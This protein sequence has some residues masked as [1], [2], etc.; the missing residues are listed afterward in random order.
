MQSKTGFEQNGFKTIGICVII[1]FQKEGTQPMPLKLRTIHE[2]MRQ[3][4]ETG[5]PARD[6]KFCS[7]YDDLKRAILN[8]IRK[9]TGCEPNDTDHMDLNTEFQSEEVQ[10]AF[11]NLCTWF[12]EA[13]PEEPSALQLRAS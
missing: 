2:K 9:E 10:Q 1:A 6:A 11:D 7:Q 3:I 5:R 13:K 12:N 4:N 8:A